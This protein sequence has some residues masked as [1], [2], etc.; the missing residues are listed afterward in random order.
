MHPMLNI[1]VRA[2]RRAGTIITRSL[3]RLDE[4]QVDR[5]GHQEFVTQIDREAEAVTPYSPR[6]RITRSSPKSPVPEAAIR[7]L[8]GLSTL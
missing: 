8:S 6:I 3:H 7:N 1:A 5:K 4:I 2:A